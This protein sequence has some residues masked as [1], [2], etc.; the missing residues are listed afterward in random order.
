MKKIILFLLTFVIAVAGVS[1]AVTPTAQPEKNEEA[2]IHT[3]V[4]VSS[5]S[6]DEEYSIPVTAKEL[7]EPVALESTTPP[8]HQEKSIEDA[9]IEQTN[10]NDDIPLSYE[11]QEQLQAACKE[12]KVPYALALGLIEKETNFRNVV[13][14]DGASAGYMQIQQKWHWDRM[15]RL[16]VTDLLDPKGNFR[17][18]LDFLSELYGKYDDWSTAITVYNMGH[19]PGYIT[20]Y[21]YAVMDNYARWQE[22]IQIFD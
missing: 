4:A 22:T 7:R 6:L 9:P 16:G 17:V 19:D 12:F 15:E 20:N 10:Y 11:E 8:E 5:S 2:A 18:G 13:G 3:L 21:A 14:D 1:C